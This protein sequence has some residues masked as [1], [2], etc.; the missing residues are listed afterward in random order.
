M[1]NSTRRTRRRSAQTAPRSQGRFA[2][3]A[4][5][6]AILVALA[7][8]FAFATGQV[9]FVPDYG[10]TTDTGDTTGER[11]GGAGSGFGRSSG[12]GGG[13]SAL[14]YSGV[15]ALAVGAAAECTQTLPSL[16]SANTRIVEVKLVADQ[17]RLDAGTASCFHLRGRSAAD[18]QWYDLTQQPG[19]HI[20]LDGA[21]TG[22]VPQQGS[23]HRFAL[24]ITAAPT[25]EGRTVKVRASYTPA[26]G[27]ALTCATEVTLHVTR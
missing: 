27:T 8:Q 7:Y 19:T 15:G 25:L 5:A 13:G 16:S 22:L 6:G 12:S 23:N 20:E 4:V 17:T 18:N 10:P 9:G 14:V 2:A 24:P 26:G 1:A 11:P 21:G 3:A